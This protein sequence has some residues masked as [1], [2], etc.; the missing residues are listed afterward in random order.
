MPL[1]RPSVLDAVRISDNTPVVLRR[2]ATWSDEI[3]I[4]LRLEQLRSDPRNRVAPLLDIFPL[5]DSDD[6]L[7]VVIPLLRGYYDPPFSC[8]RQ[9]LHALVQLLEV[10]CCVGNPRAMLTSAFI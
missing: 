3:P 6:E 8:P 4:L 7:L 1:Q 2:A 10:R 5:P 9:V